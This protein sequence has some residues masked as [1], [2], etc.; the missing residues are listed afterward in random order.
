MLTKV[1]IDIILE[2]IAFVELAIKL[3]ICSDKKEELKEELK[4][5]KALV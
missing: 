4:E 3:A 1:E 2:D 5:L